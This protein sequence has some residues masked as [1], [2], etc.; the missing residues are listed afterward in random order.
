MAVTVTRI[1]ENTTGA[2]T[3]VTIAVTTAP[4][5]GNLLILRIVAANSGASGAART[6]ASVTD[7]NGGTTPIP[8]RLMQ[9]SL[10]ICITR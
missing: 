7:T 8:V 1:G 5:Q 6:I 2:I 3:N 10:S 9:V 4:T